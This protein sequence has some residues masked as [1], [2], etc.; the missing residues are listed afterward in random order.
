MSET[1]VRAAEFITAAVMGGD[2]PPGE[3]RALEDYLAVF[4][5][6]HTAALRADLDRVKAERDAEWSKE[7]GFKGPP[8]DPELARRHFEVVNRHTESRIAVLEADLAAAREEIAS[9]RSKLDEETQLLQERNGEVAQVEKSNHALFAALGEERAKHSAL[10][11]AAQDIQRTQPLK[12]LGTCPSHYSYECNCCVGAF[13][14]ALADLGAP[15]KG[16]GK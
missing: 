6:Q 10:V 15:A 1:Q 2:L 11:K 9:L 5:D 8:L 14:S 16:E 4:L 3:W 7:L 13:R 12:H